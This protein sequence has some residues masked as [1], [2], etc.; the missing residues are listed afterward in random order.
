MRQF[1]F[2]FFF[3]SFSTLLYGFVINNKPIVPNDNPIVPIPRDTFPN[4]EA[5]TSGVADIEKIVYSIICYKNY[6]ATTLYILPYFSQDD[7]EIVIFES[8]RG[9]VFTGTIDLSS[10]Q[11][12]IIDTPWGKGVYTIIFKVSDNLILQG[13]FVIL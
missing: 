2:F 8:V 11:P 7:V 4:A 13:D 3:L 6:D 1:F 10:Y 5:P 9:V 12:T